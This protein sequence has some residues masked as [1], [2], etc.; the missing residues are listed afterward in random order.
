MLRYSAMSSATSSNASLRLSIPPLASINL[1]LS[2]VAA[3][4][5]EGL[6]FLVQLTPTTSRSGADLLRLRTRTVSWTLFFE[7]LS[8]PSVSAMIHRGSPSS[9]VGC[10]SS[11]LAD[12]TSES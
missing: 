11:I 9:I 7:R 4:H 6:G 8:S 12:A 5:H 3:R 1:L 2:V 10:R